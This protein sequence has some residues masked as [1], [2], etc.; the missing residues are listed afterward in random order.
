MENVLKK[1]ANLKFPL[2]INP[3]KSVD[4]AIPYNP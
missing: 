4:I 2:A 3:N 1:K